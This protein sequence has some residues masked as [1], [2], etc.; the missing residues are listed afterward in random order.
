M[1]LDP[2]DL[3]ARI[4]QAAQSWRPGCKAVDVQPLEG[5]TVSIVFKAVVTGAGE[6]QAIVIKVAPPGVPPVRNRDVLRQGRYMAALGSVAGVAVPAVLFSDPGTSLDV[7]PFFVTNLVPGV[8]KEPHLGLP[9]AEPVDP[10]VPERALNAVR[11]MAKI[12]SLRPSDIGLADEPVMTP[13]DEIERWTRTLETVPDDTRVGYKEARAAL[14]A[15]VPPA[16][17]PCVIHGDYR[18][19]NMLCEGEKVN[20]IIDWE[21]AA[22]ADPRIDLTWMLFFTEEAHHPVA[23]PGVV[24]GMPSDAELLSEYERCVGEPTPD[25][26][27]F[28]CMTRYKE[29]AAMAL[30]L[31][32]SKKTGRNIDRAESY[33]SA[34]LSLLQETTDRCAALPRT[35]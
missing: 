18:L 23:H 24:S 7:P 27:W 17:P 35:S 21:L 11:M 2:T 20:A 1:S 9:G 5:G 6:D 14:M 3:A 30:I 15:T 28:H 8:C 34:I 33:V 26:E 13:T 19:G 4:T 29:A 22:V 10:T 12:R 16:L 32:L 31:K 25:L